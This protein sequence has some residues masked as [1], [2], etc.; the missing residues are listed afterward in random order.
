[1]KHYSP[2]RKEAI[3][4]KMAPPQSMT[5]AEV[6]RQEGISTA[7]LYN[8]RKSARERGAILPSR[9]NAPGNGAAKR[10]SGLSSKLPV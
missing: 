8:W 10:S 4:Q 3:L 2:E 6:A 5:V 9:S 7:S 1:M